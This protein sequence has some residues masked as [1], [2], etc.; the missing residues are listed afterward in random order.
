MKNIKT[1]KS[2]VN[3]TILLA[4]NED[5][6]NEN[7]LFDSIDKIVDFVKLKFKSKDV[8][9]GEY[10]EHAKKL[11]KE[12]FVAFV[13]NLIPSYKTKLEQKD[14][15]KFIEKLDK[16][17]NNIGLVF[18]MTALAYIFSDDFKEYINNLIDIEIGN[19][20]AGWS[21][22]AT[23]MG[24][25][26]YKIISDYIKTDLK[27]GTDVNININT[28][29][30]NENKV[31]IDFSF[32]Y[33]INAKS[34]NRIIYN[35]FVRKIA[36]YENKEGF[37]IEYGQDPY[38]SGNKLVDSKQ[39]LIK[40]NFYP[41]ELIDLLIETG[42]EIYEDRIE[43]AKSFMGTETFKQLKEHSKIIDN[44]ESTRINLYISNE[45]SGVDRLGAIQIDNRKNM[46][47]FE[48]YIQNMS[49]EQILTLADK[50]SK[51]ELQPHPIIK[52]RE[53]TDE[54]KEIVAPG[55]TRRNI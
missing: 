48:F 28:N 20:A 55:S 2:F 16:Y 47:N 34:M 41:K 14:K 49:N 32:Y 42:K 23:I 8:V 44:P 25:I 30:N 10:A 1:Y 21:L 5:I 46:T 33:S 40:L 15:L 27:Y 11:N 52:Y 51:L 54:E 24:F 22:Y 13:K 19:N 12:D 7:I 45:R 38:I 18:N 26:L 29:I 39:H 4:N 53:L 37:E 31:D 43:Y 36:E 3:E 50:I 35:A 17:L 9:K 6:L